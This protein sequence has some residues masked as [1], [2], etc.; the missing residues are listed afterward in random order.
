MTFQRVTFG[1]T[2]KMIFPTAPWSSVS[3]L[4]AKFLIETLARTAILANCFSFWEL[5]V[6]LLQRLSQHDLSHSQCRWQLQRCFAT[7]HG[8]NTS[9]SGTQNRHADQGRQRR[10]WLDLVRHQRNVIQRSLRFFCVHDTRF[11]WCCLWQAVSRVHDMA[12]Q[13]G[14]NH[15]NQQSW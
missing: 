10:I 2:V 13:T 12:S 4:S 6:Q 8:T 14:Q 7:D 3:T 11:L 1:S 9:G 5:Y 15:P